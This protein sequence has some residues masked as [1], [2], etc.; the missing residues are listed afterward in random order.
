MAIV[1]EKRS[2]IFIHI[3]KTA[4]GTITKVMDDFRPIGD[5][6]SHTREVLSKLLYGPESYFIF[7]WVRNPWDRLFSMYKFRTSRDKRDISFEEWFQEDLQSVEIEK[8]QTPNDEPLIPN[9]MKPQSNWL[10]DSNGM[11]LTDFVGRFEN[12]HE[13]YEQLCNILGLKKKTLPHVHKTREA[14][15]RDYYTPYLR[16]FVEYH[17]HEDIERWNYKF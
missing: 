1:S 14:N 15:Y 7:S 2:Y 4:G 5:T 10:K 17:F 8:E 13:D 3:P 6:H 16:D 12:L 11:L 9:L